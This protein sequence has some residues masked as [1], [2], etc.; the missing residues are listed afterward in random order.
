MSKMNQWEAHHEK[1]IKALINN[2]QKTIESWMKENESILIYDDDAQYLASRVMMNCI[3]YQENVTLANFLVDHG[4]DVTTEESMVLRY[5]ASRG[6]LEMVDLCLSHGADPAERDR[7][8]LRRAL[9]G[10][11]TSVVLKL[12]EHGT[13]YADF[14]Q[15]KAIQDA[16]LIACE[17]VNRHSSKPEGHSRVILRREGP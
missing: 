2:D 12:I 8:A 9:R 10:G 6:H 4:F 17:V 3:F 1:L 7:E 16:H 5:S 14:P 15:A 13:D 11:H